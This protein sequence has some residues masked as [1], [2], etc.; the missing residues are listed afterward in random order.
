M[1]VPVGG[2]KTYVL[3]NKLSLVT[4]WKR[5]VAANP[6]RLFL[7]NEQLH[8]HACSAAPPSWTHRLLIKR[9]LIRRPRQFRAL[10]PGALCFQAGPFLPADGSQHQTCIQSHTITCLAITSPASDV[11]Q[12]KMIQ[13][14]IN[15]AEL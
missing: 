14:I 1:A 9:D 15:L 6:E 13:H 8:H 12:D 5:S 2:N 4:I 7:E 3:T 11:I 10:A